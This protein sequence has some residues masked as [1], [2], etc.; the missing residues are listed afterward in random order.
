VTETS[1]VLIVDDNEEVRDALRMIFELDGFEV[2]AEAD[3]G[4]EATT[5]AL[6]HDPEIVVL[7]YMMPK[8]DGEGTAR[9]LRAMMPDVRILAFSAILDHKPYW[10][11]GFL[12]KNRLADVV[13]IARGLVQPVRS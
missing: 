10:A 9:I 6:A 3:N 2:V 4:L 12:T 7:D 11:D 1:T 5:L 8:R 13:D